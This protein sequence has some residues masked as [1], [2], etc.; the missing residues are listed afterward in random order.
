[1]ENKVIL[2]VIDTLWLGGAQ[3]VVRLIMENQISNPNIHLLVL[4]R[5][6]EMI[7]VNHPNVEVVD[8][9]WKW[10]FSQARRALRAKIIALK[11]DVLHC[12]LPKSQTLGALMK[13]RF[14]G[15]K[16]VFQEQGDILDA[17]PNNLPVY[18]LSRRS[19]DLVIPCSGAVRDALIQKAGFDPQKISVLYNPVGVESKPRVEGDHEVLRIGFAGR[20]TRHKGWRDAVEAVSRFAIMHPN[21]SFRFTVAGTG[22]ESLLLQNALDKLPSNVEA[23][24]LGLVQDMTLF[25]RELDI[26][27]MPS[28]LEPM[29]MV[30]IE[31]ML[32]GV[33][34]VATDV[35]GMNEVLRHNENALL[36][37]VK[38]PE[39]ITQAM[40][41]LMDSEKRH[42]LAEKGRQYAQNHL[43][44]VFLKRLEDIYQQYL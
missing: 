10:D 21:R 8:T 43:P 32:F 25:Y 23:T 44:S 18:R 5:T 15:L 30:H 6:R 34:V 29:G 39:E 1:M 22:K 36:V 2:H 19:I 14:F 24:F 12:H 38:S 31:A 41:S 13:Q 27:L 33:A 28:H 42:A 40:D 16:L 4:R 26:L 11:P 7:Q 20:I 17:I 35:P 9:G 37:S 3:Q